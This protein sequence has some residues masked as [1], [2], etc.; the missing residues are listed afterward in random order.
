MSVAIGCVGNRLDGCHVASNSETEYGAKRAG[1][2][3]VPR[4]GSNVN[5]PSN[6]MTDYI[7]VLTTLPSK[8]AAQAVAEVLLQERLA[9]CV[10]VLGP[11]E[12][13]YWWQGNLETA[14]EWQCLAKSRL[15]LYARLE[16][17]IRRAHPYD[18]P[19]IIVSRIETGH[20]AYLDWL[21]SELA[22]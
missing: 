14:E 2:I 9:A 4:A 17:A 7:Q 8:A 3:V 21:Q 15:Q 22:R 6:D 10:Q 18:V 19:E 13:R 1:I 16:E 20:P 12:S 11:V 5:L